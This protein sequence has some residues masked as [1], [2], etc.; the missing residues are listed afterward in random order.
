MPALKIVELTKVFK[1]GFKQ[2]KVAALDGLS[3]EIDA[4]QIV[5]Y[6]GPNGAGKTTTFKLLL[7]LLRIT[8]GE[9]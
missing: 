1:G 9:A 8:S 6:L 7:G 2:K 3:L 5:G 4:G